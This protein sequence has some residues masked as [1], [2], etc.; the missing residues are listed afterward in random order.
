MSRARLRN[1]Q[2]LHTIASKIKDDD[3]KYS[4]EYILNLYE[5][6]YISQVALA[7]HLIKSSTSKDEKNIKKA[8]ETLE[9]S[10]KEPIDVRMGRDYVRVEHKNIDKPQ[11]SIH[12]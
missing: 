2:H 10:R 9:I 11:S 12:F 3:I 5:R 6:N 1:L 4:I 7:T 8:K